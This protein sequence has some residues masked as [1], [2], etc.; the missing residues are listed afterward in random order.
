MLLRLAKLPNM[1]LQYLPVMCFMDQLCRHHLDYVEDDASQLEL[2][3]DNNV[4]QQTCDAAPLGVY[5]R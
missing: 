1:F 5:P 2:M 4:I 3:K